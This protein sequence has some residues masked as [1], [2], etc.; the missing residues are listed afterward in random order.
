MLFLV[1][2][3]ERGVAALAGVLKPSGSAAEREC[4]D[5]VVVGAGVEDVA[6]SIAKA[7]TPVAG[8]P[9]LCGRQLWPRLLLWKTPPWVLANSVCGLRGSMTSAS[10]SRLVRPLFAVAQVVPRSLLLAMPPVSTAA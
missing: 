9:A 8:S 7:A 2:V 10:M 5:A 3:S 6:G 4:G 1:C